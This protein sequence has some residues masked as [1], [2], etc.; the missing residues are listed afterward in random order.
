MK[1]DIK[2]TAKFDFTNV[3][4][5]QNY[6]L[7]IDYNSGYGLWSLYIDSVVRH[8][9]TGQYTQKSLAFACGVSKGAINHWLKRATIVYRGKEYTPQQF[10]MI[11]N[12]NGV[13][14]I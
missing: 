9:I 3:T 7:Y 6:E 2:P 12:I 8:Y 11:H 13:N 1:L 4:N 14:L 5:D 10:R